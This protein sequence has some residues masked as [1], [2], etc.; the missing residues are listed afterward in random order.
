MQE[1]VLQ[2]VDHD[3]KQD[4]ARELTADQQSA[5]E[6]IQG[7]RSFVQTI[8]PSNPNFDDSREALYPV[9]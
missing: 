8:P 5:E 1:Y 6:W 4:D 2:L 3:V 9:R 7:L